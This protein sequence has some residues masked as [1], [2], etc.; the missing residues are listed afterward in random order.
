MKSSMRYITLEERKVLEK[1]AEE[2]NILGYSA[3]TSLMCS[4]PDHGLKK[5]KKKIVL[6]K[7]EVKEFSLN[8]KS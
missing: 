2:Y 1:I 3:P 5:S 6:P 7:K 8:F 4:R